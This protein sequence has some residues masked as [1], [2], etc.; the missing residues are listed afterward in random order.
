[1]EGRGITL[2]YGMTGRRHA[3]LPPPGLRRAVIPRDS[4]GLSSLLAEMAALC[5]A[6]DAQGETLGRLALLAGLERALLQKWNSLP[7]GSRH[8]TQAG[9][10]CRRSHF[11][12]SEQMDALGDSVAA[13]Q[14]RIRVT[15]EFVVLFPGTSRGGVELPQHHEALPSANEHGGEQQH[16]SLPPEQPPAQRQRRQHAT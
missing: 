8:H 11:A 10:N 7:A 13:Q 3:D 6:G 14:G 2:P 1:M 9:V 16:C 12:A 5:S 15:G 4:D